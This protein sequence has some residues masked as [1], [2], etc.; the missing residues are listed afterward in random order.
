MTLDLAAGGLRDRV[1]LDQ[2]DLARADLVDLAELTADRD[3]GGL[4]V[5]LALAADF[6][7]DHQ[8]LG[9]VGAVLALPA[10]AVFQAFLSTYL[11]ERGLLYDP[12]TDVLDDN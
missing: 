5:E 10:A 7:D 4:E 2:H 6:L 11:H 9:A 1:G 3:T 8:L 12:L